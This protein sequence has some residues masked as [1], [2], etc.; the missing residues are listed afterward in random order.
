MNETPAG[1]CDA[2]AIR[3][4]EEPLRIL[5]VDDDDGFLQAMKRLFHSSGYNTHIAR[6]GIE[7]IEMARKNT[8]DVVCLDLWMPGR[9]GMETLQS[10][11][12]IHQDLPV[13]MVSAMGTACTQEACAK[14]GSFRYLQKPF[15]S[16]EILRTI[17]EAAR[18]AEDKLDSEA[19]GAN[20]GV[21]LLADDH[22][23]FRAT[24]GRRLRGEGFIVDEASTGTGAVAA[25][26]KRH[27]DLGLL[28]MHMPQGSGTEAAKTI[29]EFDPTAVLAFMTGEATQNEIDSSIHHAIGICLSKPLSFEKIAQ[30]VT[31]LIDVG[32]R[33][34][35]RRVSFDNYESLSALSKGLHQLKHSYRKFHRTGRDKLMAFVVVASTLL[36]LPFLQ[37]IDSIQRANLDRS[38][39]NQKPAHTTLAEMVRDRLSDGQG[40]SM[41][42]KLLKLAQE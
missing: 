1:E 11:R 4:K 16:G 33:T 27:Y 10:L 6:D 17:E 21:I 19:R 20:R 40:E 24:L 42:E 14:M 29:H 34:R 18:L 35:M 7:A 9:N 22:D 36:S 3:S 41:E 30:K 26:R 8:Y 31:F 12:A 23:T 15:G 25:W 39:G 38:F 2:N 28:D 32:R 37:A 5:V 13:I